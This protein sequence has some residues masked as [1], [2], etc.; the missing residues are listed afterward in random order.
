[1]T[2][3]PD[4]RL[5]RPDEAQRLLLQLDVL[6]LRDPE[7]GDRFNVY[8]ADA[9]LQSAIE[10]VNGRE[11]SNYTEASGKAWLAL[12]DDVAS[13]LGLAFED[14]DEVVL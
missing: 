8:Q 2:A 4:P 11:D 14:L 6:G 3:T 1:M 13:A 5:S 12:S 7:T 10:L 9:A